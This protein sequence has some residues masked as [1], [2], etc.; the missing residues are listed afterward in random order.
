SYHGN[1]AQT[2]GLAVALS[3]ANDHRERA[4]GQVARLLNCGTPFTGQR[5]RVTGAGSATRW[6][7]AASDTLVGRGNFLTKVGSRPG[8]PVHLEPTEVEKL[9]GNT[10]WVPVTLA[11]PVIVGTDG[12]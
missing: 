6:D 4:A 7:A 2:S 12:P 5:R 8:I 9:L 3:A 1:Q 10:V 11:G